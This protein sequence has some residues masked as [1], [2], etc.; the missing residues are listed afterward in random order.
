MNSS[1]PSGLTP[2]E[3]VRL[4]AKHRRRWIAPTIVCA[5]LAA[6][7]A[8]V[9]TR[10]WQ[11]T[12]ALV[13][14]QE[15]TTAT[16][17]QHGKFTDLYEMR[18][19]Q[20]TILE[21]AKSRQVIAATLQAVG[22]ADAGEP[23]DRDVDSFRKRMSMLPPGGAEFGKTEVFYLGVKDEDRDRAIRLVRELT[24]QLDVRLRQLRDEQ[25]QSVIAELEQQVDLAARSQQFQTQRLAEFETEVGSDLGE[26]RLLHS[27]ASGQSDLRQ[28]A[29]EL[30]NESRVSSA[31]FHE[32]E[33]LLVALKMAQ[34]D[35]NELIAMPSSLLA[36]QPTLRQLKD[37]LVDAQLRAAR[38][39][40]TRTEN[41]PRVQVAYDAVSQ[42]RTDLHD[43]LQVAVRGVQIEL[44]LHR[45][46]YIDLKNQLHEIDVRLAKLAERRAE[47]SNRV[48]SVDN[49]RQVL[50][51]ARKQLIEARAE[52]VAANSASLVTVVDQPD[53]GTH[54][55]G[56]GRTMVLL[57]GTVCGLL[58]GL[59]LTFLTVTPNA[60][61]ER[62]W[63]FEIEQPEPPVTAFHC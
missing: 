27:A 55:A 6:A 58:L 14:R 20:E 53:G 63:T 41:H 32:A 43:E 3:C 30:E 38:L 60:P 40:G 44:D 16:T 51:Q 12:Q 4:L 39:S 24:R 59:G 8:L 50:D 45:N 22:P 42:V 54:P 5:A 29:V 46:R 62:P 13:V 57:A 34:Q 15:V 56:I 49:S 2:A 19:F 9:M 33:Q 28:Q 7:Y 17:G 37:G 52:Q 18:T 35:S 31:K 26:L 47:Y 36:S 48:A 10:Y 23:T 25:A 11:A 1:T 21:L 61:V